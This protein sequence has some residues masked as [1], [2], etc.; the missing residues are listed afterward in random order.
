M[1]FRWFAALPILIL[2]SATGCGG[3]KKD[4]DQVD[5]G[6]TSLIQHALVGKIYFLPTT[7]R[8]LPDFSTLKPVGTPAMGGSCT[9]VYIHGN[10]P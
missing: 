3:Q 7:T 4:S 2:I 10:H 6:S 9:D 8:R 5:F 1:R